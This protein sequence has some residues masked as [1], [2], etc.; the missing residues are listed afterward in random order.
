[1]KKVGYKVYCVNTVS[2]KV[3]RLSLVF[4]SVPKCLWATSP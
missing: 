1:L 3:V 4:L 2:D